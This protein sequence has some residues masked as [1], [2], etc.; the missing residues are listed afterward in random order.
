MGYSEELFCFLGQWFSK[1]V[2]HIT[3]EILKN[4]DA[5]DVAL[6]TL[7]QQNP[8]EIAQECML[9]LSPSTPMADITNQS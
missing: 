3:A 9:L 6:E 5:S 4:I 7:I 2:E 8:F 1:F